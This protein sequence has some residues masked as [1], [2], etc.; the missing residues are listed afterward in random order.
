ME[1]KCAKC[2]KKND[3]ITPFCS[4]CGDLLTAQPEMVQPAASVMAGQDT[5]KFKKMSV[6]LLFLIGLITL[7]IYYPIWF[8]VNKDNINAMHS[9]EKINSNF[10]G[11]VLGVAVLG[12][13]VPFVMAIL[14]SAKETVDSIEKLFNL[15]YLI[16][17]LVL[18]FKVRLIFD[19][20]FN[21]YLQK[22]HNFSGVCTFFFTVLYL[23]YEINRFENIK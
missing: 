7:G 19:D 3:T 14:G 8:F 6:L 23:Q 21:K 10:I 13:I 2:G 22:K 15:V 17:F 20:H 18:S 5:P 4:S 12:I 11:F 9:D 16:I 1:A